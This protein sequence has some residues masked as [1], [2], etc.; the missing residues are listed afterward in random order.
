MVPAEIAPPMTPTTFDKDD[1]GY[2]AW[3]AANPDGYVVNILR[4]LNPSTARLHKS[5]CRTISGNPPRRGPWTGPYLKICSSSLCDLQSWAI[6]RT[7]RVVQP[8][9]T[10]RPT[11]RRPSQPEQAERLSRF[12]LPDEHVVYIGLVVTSIRKRIRQY[13]R[14]G[15][16]ASKPCWRLAAEDAQ[17]LGASLGSLCDLRGPGHGRVLDAGPVRSQCL[18]AFT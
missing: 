1:R 7:G 17:C 11:G 5:G 2:L 6:E 12:W 4:S 3:L 10:C 9:G 14:T 13:Y 16:G 8:C 18:G 15:I